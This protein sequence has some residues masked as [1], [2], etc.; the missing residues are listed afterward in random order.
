MAR[1]N[2]PAQPSGVVIGRWN[3]YRLAP[4]YHPACRGNHHR[5]KAPRR[6]LVRTGLRGCP[7]GGH[8]GNHN[9]Q[10]RIVVVVSNH[11]FAA[12]SRGVCGDCHRLASSGS[13]SLGCALR[14]VYLWGKH[15]LGAHAIRGML[16]SS[17]ICRHWGLHPCFAN[18]HP[19][20]SRPLSD[21]RVAPS[22][23]FLGRLLGVARNSPMF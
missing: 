18:P 6:T 15:P 20:Q 22:E 4:N 7:T 5:S 21:L 14:P 13:F 17:A 8:P 23:H 10:P 11:P 16:C 12:L 19:R 2:C 1:C 9:A 3:R